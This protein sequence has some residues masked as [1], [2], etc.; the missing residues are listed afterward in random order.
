MLK[1]KSYEDYLEE[2]VEKLGSSDGLPSRKQS[3]R[4]S[5]SDF[6]PQIPVKMQSGFGRKTSHM[7]SHQ[8]L[9]TAKGPTSPENSK[10]KVESPTSPA[11]RDT[12][13]ARPTTPSSPK[14][15]F[16]ALIDEDQYFVDDPSSGLTIQASNKP[17]PPDASRRRSSSNPVRR[18]SLFGD[19]GRKFS[20]NMSIASE[21]DRRE[22]HLPVVGEDGN[23]F[24]LRDIASKDASRRSEIETRYLMKILRRGD[25]FGSLPNRLIQE[26]T[27]SIEH[28][29][30]TSNRTLYEVGDDS[31]QIYI[32]ISGR[33]RLKPPAAESLDSKHILYS[34]PTNSDSEIQSESCVDLT[35]PGSIFGDSDLLRSTTRTFA[36]KVVEDSDLIVITKAAY[37][38]TLKLHENHDSAVKMAYLQRISP[39][40]TWS[41]AA[42]S[43]FLFCLKPKSISKNEFLYKAG[44]DASD[45]FFIRSG[46]VQLRTQ[47]SKTSKGPRLGYE[48]SLLGP[49]D[50][51]GDIEVMLQLKR[52]LTAMAVCAVEVYVIKVTDFLSRLDS[53]IN[54]SLV[55]L[56]QMK[57]SWQ[58][59]RLES[60]KS[61]FEGM[62]RYSLEEVSEQTRSATAPAST[63]E[64]NYRNYRFDTTNGRDL[65]MN[66][67]F[68]PSTVAST[69]AV[70]ESAQRYASQSAAIKEGVVPPLNLDKV[71]DDYQATQ[72]MR[73]YTSRSVFNR[74]ITRER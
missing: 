42:L 65:L 21:V 17:V 12:K 19:S 57:K 70:F 72:S 16:D 29:H 13:K 54:E 47:K 60:L 30:H 34:T 48:L 38:K 59:S 49:G 36:A 6:D 56:A 61:C 44:D 66:H 58:D 43:R 33:I 25:A 39:F 41:S 73:P 26:L 18:L 55:E 50:M 11:A 69:H 37:N 27:R 4:G 23:S 20:R 8:P 3:T 71:S 31:N 15:R 2:V 35:M 32:L 24:S 14:S 64:D 51:V 22:S 1:H 46:Q 62:E 53:S 52:E 63:I 74:E 67:T 10:F 9:R 28:V 68:M 45:V 5:I 40:S 7:I